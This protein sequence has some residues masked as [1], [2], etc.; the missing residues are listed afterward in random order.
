LTVAAMA[1]KLALAA[2]LDRQGQVTRHLDRLLAEQGPAV[3]PADAA[4]AMELA[5]GVERRRRTLDA[6]IRAYSDQPGRQPPD[7]V[8]QVLRLGA[9]QI[10][11]LDRVPDFAAVN[12]AVSVCRGRRAAFAGF[13][14][15]VLRAICRG[16]SDPQDGPVPLE[17]GVIAQSPDRFRRFDR[18]VLAGPSDDEGAFLADAC[19]LNDDLAARWLKRAGSLPAAFTQAMQV[20]ARPLVVMRVNLSRTT[21]AAALADLA[22]A[23]VR[24]A[25]HENGLSVVLLDHV[26]VAALAAFNQGLVTPQ[27]PT[28]TAVA[29]ALNVAP[30]M[31][32][33]DFCAAPGAK[34]THLGELMGGRGEI[35]AVDVSPEKLDRIAE[36]ARRCGLEGIVRTMAA[37]QVASLG[38]GSFDRI[39]VDAPCSN[40][41]VLARRVEA[42]W[43]FS[44][45]SLRRLAGDQRNILLLAAT[46]LSPGG[47]LVYS[48]CSTEPEENQAVVRAF[49]KK[50]GRLRLLDEKLTLPL[51]FVPAQQ[52]HDG[53]YWAAMG[54]G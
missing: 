10:V 15:A 38:E 27:D 36:A 1:R 43:R 37:D 25:A 39:L 33:L 44:A 7:A 24:A 32:V 6:V 14:N 16:I 12:E 46:F 45:E 26:N 18:D 53:G 52:C 31:R 47:R 9:Y 5:H 30:G 22:G 3:S 11:F 42:R 29:R 35:V 34:T 20:N 28:A 23:G 13:V 2:L 8:Q 4:L 19:S 48:T 51:G 54:A 40:T 17:R 21:V 50:H 49:L 41:G